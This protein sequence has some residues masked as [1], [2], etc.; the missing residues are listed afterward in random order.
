MSKL[1]PSKK[2]T[3][4]NK[5]LQTLCHIH[6]LNRILR[7]TGSPITAPRNALVDLSSLSLSLPLFPLQSPRSTEA[8]SCNM[9]EGSDLQWH[10]Q[11]T[12][13]PRKLLATH[14]GR[15]I[16]HS[17]C[18]GLLYTTLNPTTPNRTPTRRP[19]RTAQ[20]L[21]P[22]PCYYFHVLI[23]IMNIFT[24]IK[25]SLPRQRWNEE[26]GQ[27]IYSTCSLPIVGCFVGFLSAV[28]GVLPKEVLKRCGPVK[29]FTTANKK[30]IKPHFESSS[31]SSAVAGFL[32]LPV[33]RVPSSAPYHYPPLSRNGLS[34][35]YLSLFAKCWTTIP[36]TS[37][38]ISPR[39]PFFLPWLDDGV[40]SDRNRTKIN[41][42][43]F[44]RRR[45]GVST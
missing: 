23:I 25:I 44:S 27:D 42:A 12:W 21:I 17:I 4:F 20:L 16:K 13:T 15:R 40:E 38:I 24:I 37:A 14:P 43:I 36:S 31:A 11:G 2:E 8:A 3:N 29:Y 32:P 19:S 28:V 22:S 41:A 26:V 39:E 10:I 18:Q 7:G 1:P 5:F 33:S 30:S 9:H 35:L 45:G 6:D 34:Q